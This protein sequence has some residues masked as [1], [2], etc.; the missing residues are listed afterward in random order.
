M[1]DTLQAIEWLNRPSGRSCRLMLDSGRAMPPSDSTR[2]LMNEMAIRPGESVLDLGAG[3]GAVGL[4]ALLL[5]AGEVWFT[6]IDPDCEALIKANVQRLRDDTGIEAP[7]HITIG[8]LFAP[9]NAQR[10]DHI[11]VNPPSVP[12][13]DES[14]APAYRSGPEG[15]RFHDAIQSLAAYSLRDGGRLSFVQGS[16]SNRP[17]S[18]ERLQALGY[19]CRVSE[20]IRRPLR[21]H[22]PRDWLQALASRGEAELLQVAGQWHETR[23]VIEASL[24]RAARTGVMQR[25]EQ[26]GVPVRR[27]PHLN[28]ARTVAMAAQE[29][30]VPEH[31]MIKCI[32]L[33]DRRERFVL[34]CLAGDADLDPQR[35][36][37][38]LPEFSR[39]SFSSP[40][41]ITRVT[42]HVLGSVAPISLV[43]S[44]PVVLD[45]DLAAR[46]RVNI[47]SGDPRLG[48]ELDLSALLQVLGPV[49]R[50]APIRKAS[51]TAA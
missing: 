23:C 21:P 41:E 39:L 49:A 2:L 11:L 16:L 14:L 47:S 1:S 42:G 15:R 27:L 4:A 19:A 40:D 3:S 50:F 44:I 48:L 43:E 9:V 33:K 35:V 7:V 45:A 46:S 8:N 51:P 37:E 18:L 10:F 22:Y 26:A 24:P 25:L 20:S 29:R 31:E 13:P 17:R 30:G 12:S 36:R 38:V 32:L 34:A 28:E 5:G 6:E